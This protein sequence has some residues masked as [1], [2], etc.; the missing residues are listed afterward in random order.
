MKLK[1]R[2]WRGGFH[3]F[4]FTVT[5]RLS[6]CVLLVNP[7]SYFVATPFTNADTPCSCVWPGHQFAVW[8][9]GTVGCMNEKWGMG[10]WRWEIWLDVLFAGIITY[11]MVETV[12]VIKRGSSWETDKGQSSKDRGNRC[13]CLLRPVKLYCIGWPQLPCSLWSRFHRSVQLYSAI[14]PGP[15]GAPASAYIPRFTPHAHSR[16]YIWKYH[17]FT[18][19]HKEAHSLV[20]KPYE[21]TCLT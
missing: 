16:F 11:C 13:V 18:H 15:M 4:L 5:V 20:M 19:L 17:I 1:Q 8:E 12:W 10:S 6:E 14:L 21:Q 3:F 9:V 7:F 2:S